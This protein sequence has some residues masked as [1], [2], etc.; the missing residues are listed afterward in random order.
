MS[1]IPAAGCCLQ[2]HLFATVNFLLFV[3]FPA[4]VQPFPSSQNPL[5]EQLVYPRP[6]LSPHFFFLFQVFLLFLTELNQIPDLQLPSFMPSL[7]SL[8]ASRSSSPVFCD[9]P[10]AMMTWPI[11]H[12]LLTFDE[13]A[14]KNIR[15]TPPPPPFPSPNRFSYSTISL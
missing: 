15:F 10:S 3:F 2:W 9:I 7:L 12:E 4:A 11:Q 13:K 8:A 6:S 14:S 1:V 5:F